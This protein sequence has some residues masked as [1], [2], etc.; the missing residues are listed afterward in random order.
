MNRNW[1]PFYIEREEQK[2]LLTQFEEAVK[3]VKLIEE[4]K[5]SDK[6]KDEKKD[7]KKPPI[8]KNWLIGTLCA[9]ISFPF[10]VWIWLILFMDIITRAKH[11]PL[12]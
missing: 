2:S 7:D 8:F 9:F 10:F 1:P 6:P 5:K 3:V 4:M 12:P 11:L